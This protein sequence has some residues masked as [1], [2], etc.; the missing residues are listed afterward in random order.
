MDGRWPERTVEDRVGK[1]VVQ[2]LSWT[3]EARR[4]QESRRNPRLKTQSAVVIT[5]A[6]QC[7]E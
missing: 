5:R 6:A 2:I 4:H 3:Q 7:Y 1:R